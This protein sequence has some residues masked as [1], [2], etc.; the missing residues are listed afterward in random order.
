MTVESVAKE[1]GVSGVHWDIRSFKLVARPLEFLS[2]VKWRLPSL[3]VRQECRDSFPAEAGSQTLL[4]GGG[5]KT[6]DLLE[7]WRDPLC[8]SQVET[9]MSGNFLSYL[10]GVKDPFEVQEGRWDFF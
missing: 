5:W 7:L 8:S 3:E 10:K 1:S 9:A 6:R 2:S 4:S